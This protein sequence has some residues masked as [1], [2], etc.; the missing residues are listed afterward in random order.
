M[1][2]L[3]NLYNISDIV[4]PVHFNS[5]DFFNWYKDLDRMCTRPGSGTF[6][7]NHIFLAT[8]TKHGCLTTDA[9]KGVDS[10]VHNLMKLNKMQLVDKKL[11]G[12][13]S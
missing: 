9:V 4:T 7:L 10:K 6:Q 3:M 12:L 2:K 13:G 11:Q 5:K 8:A 1:D